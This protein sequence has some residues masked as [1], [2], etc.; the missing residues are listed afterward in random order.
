VGTYVYPIAGAT[1]P[2][3]VSSITPSGSGTVNTTF[4]YDANGNMTAGNG[5]TTTWTSFNKVASIGQG[6]NTVAFDYDSEHARI[7]QVTASQ[8]TLY[9]FGIEKVTG[10]S[11]NV[12]W[13]EYISA[14]G[15]LVGEHYT[16]IASGGG[17]TTSMRYFIDDHLGSVAVITDETGAVVERLS[18]DAWGKRRFPTGADDPTGSITS[19]TTKGFTGHEM[20]D[21]VGLVNM[22]GRVY[23]P[24]LGRFMSAD[25]YVQDPTD[26][27][28]LNRYAYVNNNPLSYTD[29]T[30]YFSLGSLIR[31]II[32]VV[33]VVVAVVYGQAW[34]LSA[35]YGS[36]ATA[37]AGSTAAIVSG[38]AAGAVG[39]AISAGIMSGG[40][41][42]SILIGAVGGA[43]FGAL[44][45]W[46]DLQELTDLSGRCF[47]GA[48]LKVIRDENAKS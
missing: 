12:Q 4:T 5:R 34:A 30:G 36:G 43:A 21:N 9:M 42:K 14:G 8:T 15:M 23:D 26:S 33:V 28:S 44:G 11:G 24:Q 3:A 38:A 39:G 48:S 13:N 47:S 41:L 16:S 35:I 40:D 17:T 29:P 46:S 10:T 31:T 6:V 7:R 22:N 1:G 32:A 2:H 37:A 45:G 27:Q 19:Q 18:Y 20:I 25:P